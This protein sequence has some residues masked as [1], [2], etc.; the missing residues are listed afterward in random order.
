MLGL[1]TLLFVPLADARLRGFQAPQ[2]WGG[3]PSAPEGPAAPRAPEAAAV[4]CGQGPP[5]ETEAQPTDGGFDE[6]ALL[7]EEATPTQGTHEKTVQEWLEHFSDHKTHIA[8]EERVLNNETVAAQLAKISAGAC[9]DDPQWRDSDGDGCEIYHFAIES[10]KM[11]RDV[12]CGGGGETRSS[13]GLR[14]IKVAA[15]AT[16]KVFCPVTCGACRKPEPEPRAPEGPAA[17]SLAD[18][19]TFL[20]VGV[21]SSEAPPKSAESWLSHMH[22]HHSRISDE[23]RVLNNDTVAYQ[24]EQLE[25][26]KQRGHGCSD[27]PH[28]RDAD[29]DGCEIYKFAIESG[30]TTRDLVCSGGGE[31]EAPSRLRGGRVRVVADATAKVF[32]PVTCGLC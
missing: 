21:S 31:Q 18:D 26:E 7:Q 3:A 9:F 10:G 6:L 5:V 16:A 11:T 30:K 8:A 13:P 27:D 4:A 14:G 28:W 29:G 17:E 25:L 24:L 12:A 22:D 2:P 19:V 20:Q 1:F 32:C 23:D 15:D